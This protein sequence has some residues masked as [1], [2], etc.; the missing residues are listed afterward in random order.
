VRHPK[1]ILADEPTASLDK[2]SGRE[3]VELL[4]QLAR[5]EG[6]AVLLVTHDNRILDIADRIMTLEDG[7]MGT[8][9]SITSTYAG[10]LLTALSH[11]PEETD[12]VR[13]LLK[14][15]QEGDFVDLLKT[16]GGEVEQFLN[17]LNLGNHESMCVLFEN[18]LDGLLTKIAELLDASAVGLFGRDGEPLRSTDLQA[19]SDP[20]V[21][22]RVVATGRILNAS[23]TGLGP[24]V[25]SA[26][27]VPLR[28]RME[29]IR[30][31][32][33]LVNKKTGGRFTDADERAF[34]DFAAPLGVLVEAWQRLLVDTS[35]RSARTSTGRP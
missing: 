10:H 33:Q 11:H 22:A 28:D 13:L 31:V 14:D 29:D 30:V 27:C 18:L 8:F 4:R 5:R 12:H 34:R 35:S 1:I 20:G 15:L 23:G 16:L 24:G 7:R 9:G 17:I 21:T 25:H 3:V 2:Q 19:R 32:A 6:C 26:L